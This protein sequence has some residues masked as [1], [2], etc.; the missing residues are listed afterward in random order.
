MRR[1]ILG[2]STNWE[3]LCWNWDVY[4]LLGKIRTEFNFKSES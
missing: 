3:Q 4:I 2:H 1:E